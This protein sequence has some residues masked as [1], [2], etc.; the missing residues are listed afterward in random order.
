VVWLD[1]GTVRSV[2]LTPQLDAKGS[3]TKGVTYKRVLD[4]GLAEHGQFVAIKEDGTGRV[5][6]LERN[7]AGEGSIRGIWEFQKSVG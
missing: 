4:V 2:D 3:S 5:F 6:K 1:K 7:E